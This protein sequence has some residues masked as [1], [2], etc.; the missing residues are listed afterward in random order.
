[1]F[2]PDYD[3]IMINANDGGVYVSYDNLQDSMQWVSKNN[4]YYSTQFYACAI[5]PGETTSDIIIG[6]MQDNNTYYTNSTDVTSPWKRLSG[7]DG[8]YCA[9]TEDEE[10]YVTC[11]Q[12]GRLFLNEVDA[13]GNITAVE[14]IDPEDGPSSYNWANSYKLDPN[15]TKML[16]WNARNGIMRLDLDDVIIENDKTNKQDGGWVDVNETTVNGSSGFITDIEMCKAAPGSIWYGSS[17]GKMYRTDNADT[18]TPVQ[19]ELTWD[20]W[21][22]GGYVS[23]I[24]VNPYDPLKIIMSFANYGVQSIWKTLDGGVTWEHISGNLEENEDGEGTGPAVLWVEYYPDGTLFAGTSIGLFSTVGTDGALTFWDYESGI[25][26][27]VINHMDYRPY[28]G[29]FVV[30]THGQGVFSTNLPAAFTGE[31]ELEKNPIKLYPTVSNDNI[32]IESETMGTAHIFDMSGKLVQT[33]QVNSEL[34]TINVSSFRQGAYLFALDGEKP[35]TFI[36]R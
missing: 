14:R 19:T 27:V 29:K 10:F 26:N 5:E 24:A 2:H 1:M 4:G 20:D 8:M 34:T 17:N 16:Y 22:N 21:P 6:G 7:G 3:T 9:I 12:Y 15:D 23:S 11:L 28:D 13:D 33:L 36:V 31:L 35:T 18:D 25:G 32:F 30:A